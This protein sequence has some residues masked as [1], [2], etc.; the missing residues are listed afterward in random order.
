MA[1]SKYFNTIKKYYDKKIYK[2]AHIK[3]FVRTGN[4]T[5]E[6]YKLITG[7]DYQA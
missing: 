6:E 3:V 1:Q 7:E 4:L 5:E 2:K